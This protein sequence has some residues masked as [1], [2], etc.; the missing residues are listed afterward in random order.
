MALYIVPTPIGNLQDIT[1]RALEILKK[2]DFIICE[3]TRHSQKLLAHYQ[4]KKKLF[5]YYQ[6]K[7]RIQAEK[8]LP[9]LE[10]ND[11]ALI[12]D[13]GTPLISDPGYILVRLCLQKKIK[14]I[15]LP[16][17]TAFVPALIASGL[18]CSQFTFIGFPPRK[19]G[20][21]K[22]LLKNIAELKQTAI[23]YE[24]GLRIKKLLTIAAE[25]SPRGCFV[26]ARELTKINEEYISGK[27]DRLSESIRDNFR[28][29]C[30][31]LIYPETAES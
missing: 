17:A 25:I 9:L 12:T 16:G 1:L 27:F 11:G 5:S 2:A 24:N 7:E 30:I 28:G 19:P 22:K 15:A 4:I 3:D 6:P 26:I 14:V 8:L 13:S 20:K 23:F 31:V 29:E 21:L 18:P 10:K